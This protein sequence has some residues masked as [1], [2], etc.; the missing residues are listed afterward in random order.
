[1]LGSHTTDGPFAFSL[2]RD[3]PGDEGGKELWFGR[4]VHG[5]RSLLISIYEDEWEVISLR[6]LLL[7]LLL[8]P[9]T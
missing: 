8:L 1:M 4:S 9:L 3:H 2:L 6:I 7:L 5:Q